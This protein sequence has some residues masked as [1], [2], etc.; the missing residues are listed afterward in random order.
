[1]QEERAPRV[2]NRLPAN[3]Q[4]T[5][6]QLLREA[7]ERQDPQLQPSRQRLQDFEELNEFQGRKRREFEERIRMLRIDVSLSSLASFFLTNRA[8]Q[9]VGYLR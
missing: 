6:E 5:A 7:N 2:K 8:A 9:N 4:I 1:M 3:V